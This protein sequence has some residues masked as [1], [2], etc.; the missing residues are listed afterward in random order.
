[1]AWHGV[2]WRSM[3]WRGVPWRGVAPPDQKSRHP[4]QAGLASRIQ[5]WDGYQKRHVRR[6][7]GWRRPTGGVAPCH[8]TAGQ[9]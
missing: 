5:T 6:A 3:A 8:E 9:D 4:T 2:A 7:A 1:M